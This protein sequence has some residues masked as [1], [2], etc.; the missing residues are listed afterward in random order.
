[1]AWYSPQHSCGHS[2]EPI[3]L[4]G[5][6]AGRE[7]VLD[8]MGR[9]PCPDCRAATAQ[10]AAHDAGLPVLT[11]TAKQVGW[12]DDI[13]GK[14]ASAVTAA[15]KTEL[16]DEVRRHPEAR[17]WIDNRYEIQAATRRLDLARIGA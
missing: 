3:Q 12:A 1:M 9:H 11:G 13:R 16:L 4:Y 6:V 8:A 14:Y 7:R 5:K 10:E 15:G 17:W 2:G